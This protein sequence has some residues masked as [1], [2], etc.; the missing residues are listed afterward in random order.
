MT[1]YSLPQG[2]DEHLALGADRPEPVL[3]RVVVRVHSGGWRRRRSMSEPEQGRSMLSIAVG[4]IVC[5][6]SGES[7]T[8]TRPR[9]STSRTGNA[10]RLEHRVTRPEAAAN[11]RGRRARRR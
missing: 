2:V 4:I 8:A 3:F 5:T 7:Q 10:Q 6:L 9:E 1:W 11:E